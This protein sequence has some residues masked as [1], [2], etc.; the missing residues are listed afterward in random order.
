LEG[1]GY[2]VHGEAFPIVAD[3]ARDFEAQA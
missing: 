1:R 3:A 2:E